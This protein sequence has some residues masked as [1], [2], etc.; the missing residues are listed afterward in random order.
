MP[1]KDAKITFNVPIQMKAVQNAM[2]EFAKTAEKR[3]KE[4]LFNY[5][6]AYG[7]PFEI[8]QLKEVANNLLQYGGEKK[9]NSRMKITEQIVL[10]ISNGHLSNVG[11]INQSYGRYI[12][13]IPINAGC[14]DI[15]YFYT[16]DEHGHVKSEDIEAFLAFYKSKLNGPKKEEKKSLYKGLVKA[17]DSDK[18]PSNKDKKNYVIGF[19]QSI[20]HNFYHISD[21]SRMTYFNHYRPLTKKELLQLHKRAPEEKIIDKDDGDFSNF[22][23][24]DEL[25]LVNVTNEN[26][27]QVEAILFNYGNNEI[28]TQDA[29]K[30]LKKQLEERKGNAIDHINIDSVDICKEGLK[31]AGEVRNIDH[32]KRFLSGVSNMSNISK[33]F[34]ADEQKRI[35][36]RP[37]WLKD[38]AKLNCKSH[39]KDKFG[40]Y[41]EIIKYKGDGIWRVQPSNTYLG[42]AYAMSEEFM[43]DAEL[44]GIPKEETILNTTNNKIA[45]KGLQSSQIV[46]NRKNDILYNEK[47]DLP[48]EEDE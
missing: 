18:E 1:I 33:E 29:L 32:A 11:L 40:D 47:Y 14:I 22:V 38:G 31:I 42:S 17:W 23:E 16:N 39:A 21:G 7:Y 26:K 15:I 30:D 19:L 43:N 28:F 5:A 20:D 3:I 27:K 35:M 4:K 41:I 9:E 34:D 25:D 24:D 37:S 8:E 10:G 12:R 13:T 48:G 6:N 45:L 2:K 36:N 44:F 46:L